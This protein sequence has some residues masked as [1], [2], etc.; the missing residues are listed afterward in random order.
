MSAHEVL[1]T[2]RFERDLEDAAHYYLEQSGPLSAGRFLDDYD[3]F[4]SLVA[5]FPGHGSPIGDSGLRWRKLGVFV[6]VY[7]EREEDGAILLLRL[8]HI[9][10]NWKHHIEGLR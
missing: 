10:S 8:Y 7:C 3:S 1:T 2:E 4:V 9:S 6:A 5:A